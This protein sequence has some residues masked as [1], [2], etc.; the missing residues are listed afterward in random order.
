MI[1]GKQ[2]LPRLM[3]WVTVGLSLV[4]LIY[5]IKSYWFTI[6]LFNLYVSGK[7]Q[8]KISLLL[9]KS[10]PEVL[11]RTSNFLGLLFT[12]SIPVGRATECMEYTVDLDAICWSFASYSLTGLN[13]KMISNTFENLFKTT[14]TSPCR[15]YVDFCCS[16]QQPQNTVWA[17]G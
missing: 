4:S 8:P 7:V 13:L 14:S 9:E 16:I 10:S 5:S 2:S 6:Y 17:T 12:L 3:M 1:I 15:R 11:V